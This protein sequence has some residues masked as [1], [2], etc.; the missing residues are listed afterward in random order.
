MTWI[1]IDDTLPSNLKIGALPDR[2]FRLHIYALCWCGNQLTDGAIPTHMVTKLGVNGA[3]KHA[4]VLVDLGLWIKTSDGYQIHDYL[5]H[6]T[7][8]KHAEQ[9]KE[10]NRVRAQKA[11]ERKMLAI[12]NAVTNAERSGGVTLA[13]THTP[14]HTPTHK[15]KNS[16]VQHSVGQEILDLCN[17]LADLVEANLKE[18]SKNPEKVTRPEISK[19]W[20]TQMDLLI[21]KDS[22]EVDEVREIIEWVQADEF[23]SSNVMSPAKLRRQFDQLILKKPKGPVKPKALPHLRIEDF[24]GPYC[25]SCNQTWPCL[26]ESRKSENPF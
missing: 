2:P 25:Q 4:Q 6:Q 8:K 11:R 15:H 20:V 24:N 14:T 17:L 19:A 22:H 18:K 7:S 1:R 12:S 13:H 16:L 3:K 23:W 9:E 10:T 21:R 5:K 26:T